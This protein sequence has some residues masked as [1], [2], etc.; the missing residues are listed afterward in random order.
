MTPLQLKAKCLSVPRQTQ[1]CVGLAELGQGKG[2]L[3]Q[4][5]RQEL[6]AHAEVALPT[7]KE[8]LSFFDVLVASVAFV[9]SADG[10]LSP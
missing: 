2:K 3:L 7:V 1:L 9:A 4:W 6:R 5:L 10:G 8:A